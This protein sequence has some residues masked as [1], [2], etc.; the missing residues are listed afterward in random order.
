MILILGTTGYEQGTDP[1][2]DWLLHKGADFLKITLKEIVS[3]RRKIRIDLRHNKFYFEGRCLNDE[4]KVV[5]TRHFY[6]RRS[7]FSSSEVDQQS[8]NEETNSELEVLYSYMHLIFNKAIWLSPIQA[9]NKSKLEMLDAARRFGLEVPVTEII[10]YKSDLSTLM[11]KSDKKLIT[12]HISDKSRGFY[13]NGSK[14]V[15]A[16][17]SAISDN[18]LNELPESFFP[19]LFQQRIEKEYE[20]RVFYISG[21]CYST[22]IIMN[23]DE[24]DKKILDTEQTVYVP[25]LLPPRISENLKKV[26]QDLGLIMGSADFIKSTDGMYYFLEVNAMGQ[27]MFESNHCNYQLEKVIANELIKLSHEK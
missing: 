13:S 11:E 5:W 15:I 17:S 22:A 20:I 26:M 14:K 2:V 18:A 10:N 24:P 8:L 25:Y 9:L 4:V 12:K 27:F 23:S 6:R 19:S 3:G 7:L 1:V 16:L 21:R